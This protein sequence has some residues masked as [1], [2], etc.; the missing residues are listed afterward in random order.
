MSRTAPDQLG[1]FGGAPPAARL[2]VADA[3]ARGVILRGAGGPW[4]VQGRTA[5]GRFVGRACDAFGKD[6]SGAPLVEVPSE[7]PLLTAM[8][9]FLAW[10]SP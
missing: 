2:V 6:R 1:L 10:G 8:A 5:D 7:H 9:R 3:R 4:R